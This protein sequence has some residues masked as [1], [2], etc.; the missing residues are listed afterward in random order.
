MMSDSIFEKIA[1]RELPGQII[2]EDEEFI[3][4]LSIGPLYKGHT[5]VVPKTNPGDY[6]FAMDDESYSKLWLAARK[7]AKL[8]EAKLD[9]D[10][11][12]VWVEGFEVPHVH[13]H[14]VPGNPGAGMIGASVHEASQEELAAIRE[15]IVG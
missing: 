6:I 4:F 11:I 2:W 5:L 8:L 12:L 9:C 3:A 10:R 14:L 13:V 1:K 7:V 15:Q